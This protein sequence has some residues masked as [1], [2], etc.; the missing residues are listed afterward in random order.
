MVKYNE[1]RL[2]FVL[3][4]L[5]AKYAIELAKNCSGLFIAILWLRNERQDIL[6]CLITY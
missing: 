3:G 6:A 2:I 5:A 4:N 1:L